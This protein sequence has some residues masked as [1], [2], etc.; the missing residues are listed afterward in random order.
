MVGDGGEPVFC[1]KCSAEVQF[2]D[3]VCTRCGAAIQE[4]SRTLTSGFTPVSGEESW[5]R[6]APGKV[7]A[8]RYTIIEEIGHGGMGRVYKA[9]DKFLA[10][11]VA[12]KIIRPEY[13]S[14]PRIVE[15]FK[16]ETILARS[17]SSENVVRVHDLGESED[18]KYISMDFVEGQSLRDLIQSSGSLT[19][20]TAVKFGQQICSALRAAHKE[21]IIH[22][23]LKP[24]NVMIDR[25]GRARVMDFGLAKSITREDAKGI[26]A[27]VGTPEY[28]SP[29]Q[30]RG[31]KQDQRTDIYA[32]GLILYEMVTGR[33]VFEAE[34]L[35]GYIKKHCEVNPEPPSRLNHLIPAALEDIILK[36][37][38]KD[39]NERFQTVEEV[40]RSLDLVVAPEVSPPRPIGPLVLRLLAWIAAGS[41]VLLAAYFV[42]F[43]RP[44]QPVSSIRKSVA[45]MSFENQTGDPSQDNWRY[46]FQSLILMDLEQS[47]FLRLVS[48]PRLLHCLRELGDD[49]TGVYDQEVLDKIASIEN[50]DYFLLGIFLI[51]QGTYRI[52][53]RIIDARTHETV[54]LQSYDSVVLDGIPE[55]CDDISLWV[56]QKLGLSQDD[57]KRDFDKELKNYT[58]RSADALI[59]F[60]RGLD[61][62]EKKS[63]Y[64]Q[65]SEFFLKAVAID[66]NFALAFARLAMNCTYEGRFEEAKKHILTAMS[67]RNNLTSRERLLIEGDYFNLLENDYPRAIATF[68]ALLRIYRDDE[69]ALEHQGA[70][71]RNTEEWDKAEECFERLK[72]INP[73]N[74]ITIRN[75]SFIA[76]AMGQYEKAAGILL[77]NKGVY[78]T[79]EE[80]H[81][82]LAH[83]SFYQGRTDQALLEL[84]KALSLNPNR[85]GC[86]RLLGHIHKIRGRYSDAEACYRQLTGEES[87]DLTKIDGHFWLGHLYLLQGQYKNGSREIEE[88]LKLA[89]KGNLLYEESTFLLLKSYSYF[90]Q[91]DFVKAYEIGI[92]ARQKAVEVRVPVDEIAALQLTGLSEV[93]LDKLSEA[94][95]TGLS[96]EQIIKNKG[97][98]RLLRDCHYLEGMIA[99]ARKSWAEAVGNF[100]KAVE[101]LP[102]QHFEYDRQAVY[103]EALASA[104]FQLGDLDSARERYEKVTSLTS[105]Y[106][107]SG[108]AYAR[109]LYQL[110]R[111]Y[112]EKN[113]PEKA[114]DC[115][116]RY[117]NVFRKADLNMPD[118]E[119]ARK[120][121]ASLS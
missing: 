56:K 52:D 33:P 107:T 29:E 71:Y 44:E 108:D 63:D 6:F 70:I 17:I 64:K 14:N 40:C 102:Q 110:G 72:V 78:A 27:V 97:Y 119:D 19:I 68:A 36:C 77:E 60:F 80:F 96:M 5:E 41:A 31:E 23:D 104:L 111:I 82:D 103:L 109:S 86:I 81:V 75:L 120:R 46:S 15:H 51:Y 62:Y 87:A 8:N 118:V 106:L 3:K 85:P 114:R 30:A 13:A 76:E 50:V 88:G 105:G 101:M 16:Q 121:L 2:G 90:L 49:D 98:P 95:S 21:D 94:R 55:K 24:S 112:Q 22:R 84:E 54:G 61:L 67:L 91:E 100:T 4:A 59:C 45:V 11:T 42:F 65:S 43:H 9:I 25:T 48:R 37:L 20:S 93:E 34:S 58:T 117:L 116:Q 69:I 1:P 92:K 10:I 74:R 83:C 12:I 115:Y 113:E 18:T 79:P 26:R 89:K 38:K 28:L 7:F 35:T 39:R 57:L 73:H 66:E 53:V 47:K 32:L 99:V